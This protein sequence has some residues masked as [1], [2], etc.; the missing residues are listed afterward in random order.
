[1]AEMKQLRGTPEVQRLG[2]GEKRSN[3]TKL[4]TSILF[5]NPITDH[6]TNNVSNHTEKYLNGCGK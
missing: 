1:L 3:L 5:A 6:K 4:H 2:N